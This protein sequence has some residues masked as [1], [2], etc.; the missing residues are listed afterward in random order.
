MLCQDVVQRDGIHPCSLHR[1]RVDPARLEPL[2]HALQIRRPATEF[3]YR[4]GVPVCRYGYEVT[5]I[6]YVNTTGI[7][8]NNAQAGIAG[9]HP[10]A[11]IPPLRPVQPATA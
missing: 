4:V 2:S 8:M 9:S 1:H 5:L 6:A 7:G 3:L 11:Q 10:A